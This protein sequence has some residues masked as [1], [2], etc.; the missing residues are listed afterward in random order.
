[1]F[2]QLEAFSLD[3]AFTNY[4]HVIFFFNGTGN[5]LRLSPQMNSG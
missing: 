2:M 4:K 3:E 5:I 1:M